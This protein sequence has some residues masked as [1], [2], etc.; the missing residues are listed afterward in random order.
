[1]T[2]TTTDALRKTWDAAAPGWARWEPHWGRALQGPTDVLLDHAA[3]GSGMRVLDLACGAGSQTLRAAQ[4]VGGSGEVIAADISATMLDYVAEAARAAGL[5]NVRT[6]AS[7]AEELGLP[8]ESIDAGICR[9]GLM[10]FAD[11][12]SA[13]EAVHRLLRPGAR[14]AALVFSAPAANAFM[15]APMATLLR[16]AG[17][18]APAPGTPGLFR[19]GADGALAGVLAAAGLTDVRSD[20]IAATLRFESVDDAMGMFQQAAGAYRAAIAQLDDD[21]KAAAWADVRDEVAGYA[22]PEGGVEASLEVV[23]ASGAR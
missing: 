16:H 6:V 5:E 7:P 10:L 21:A 15:A 22:T 11:P 12:G 9:L 3:V 14:F 13:L 18:P 20:V 23:V 17:S 19:F 1:M 8:T 2:G 4:R